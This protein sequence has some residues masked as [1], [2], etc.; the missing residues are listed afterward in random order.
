M[1]RFEAIRNFRYKITEEESMSTDLETISINVENCQAVAVQT[2][3]KNGASP[4]G[5]MYVE[6][7]IDGE[8]YVAISNQNVSGNDGSLLFNIEEPSYSRVRV[9]YDR[10]SGDADLTVFIAG[11][12]Y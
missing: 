6:A 3:W 11:K 10:T 2:S 5:V 4:V 1:S 9:T 8:N 12:R 7:S